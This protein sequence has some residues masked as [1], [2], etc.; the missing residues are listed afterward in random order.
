MRLSSRLLLCA[1]AVLAGLSSTPAFT[2]PLGGGVRGAVT[3][4]SGGVLP[5]VT[6]VATSR[7]GRVLGT[8]VTDEAGGYALG[9][10]PAG[11]V[12]LRFELEGFATGSAAV[13]I[14]P[15][16]EALVEKHLALAPLAETVNVYGQASPP[17]PPP[18]PAVVPV[19]DH[20]RES[21]CGPAKPGAVPESFG[22]IRSHRYDAERLLYTKDDQLMIDGGTAN[23]LEA[24]QN[25]VVRR[26]YR[27]AGT[28]AGAVKGEHTSGLLQI[29]AADERTATAVVI[30]ACDEMMKGDFLASFN[31]EPVRTPES[32][33]I[34]VFEDAARILFADAGQMLGV[35]RRLMVIDKGSDAGLRPGQRLTLFRSSGPAKAGRTRREDP[36]PSIVGDAVIVAVRAD[37]ATIRVERAT[38][39]IAFGDRAAPQ[40]ATSAASPEIAGRRY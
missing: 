36:T 5:G 26:H 6:I 19:A 32:A 7:D 21:I 16:G 9:A 1:T 31:P 33:G 2:D 39:V 29:V 12:D 22:T 11:P 8:A 15:E 3:D 13:T 14:E 30:Y 35:P 38:D 27:A 18:P 4:D 17:P 24:G 10:L 25:L 34:P 28:K 40:D 37:S 23:G 20:D